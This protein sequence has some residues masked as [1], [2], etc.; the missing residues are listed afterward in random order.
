MAGIGTLSAGTII[1]GSAM[2][3][4]KLKKKTDSERSNKKIKDQIVGED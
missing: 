3:G 2:V 1:G 4:K